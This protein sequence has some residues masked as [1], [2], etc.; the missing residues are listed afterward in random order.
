ML[1]PQASRFWHSAIQSGLMDVQGLTACW[2]AIPPEKRDAPEHLDRRLA[3]QAVQRGH[4]TLWQAQQLLAGR[5]NG[6]R[7]DRYLLVD[8]IGHGGMGRVYLARDTR[9][10]RQ[11]ALKILAPERMNN[12]RAIARFQREARVGAQ[13]Q[14]ENLVRIYDFGESNGRHFLVMEY[15]EGKTIG[16]L[17]TQQGP[18]PAATAAR[19]ARQIALGLEHAHRK[20]LIHRDVN[21][22]NILVSHEGIAK[23]ADLG[24]AID[25]AEEERVT[26]EG[27]TVGTFDYVAPEQARHSHAADIRSDIYSLGC[28]LYHM[29]AGHVPF[30]SPSLPEK[31]FAHQAL[32]PRP[33]DQ[34]AD[35]P[36][37]LVDVVQRMMRKLP[38]GRYATPLQVAQA[39]EPFVEDYARIREGE[40]E[41]EPQAADEMGQ[42]PRLPLPQPGGGDGEIPGRTGVGFGSPANPTVPPTG[43]A[44]RPLAATGFRGGRQGEGPPGAGLETNRPA[45]A[46]SVLTPVNG[47]ELADA[48]DIPLILDLGPEPA[49]TD[50][51]PRARSW[52]G[53]DKPGKLSGTADFP[54]GEVEPSYVLSRGRSLLLEHPWAWGFALL[55]AALM[56]LLV[57]FLAAQWLFAQPPPRTPTA[58]RPR[59]AT[60]KKEES[61]PA[62]IVV[63]TSDGAEKPV[64]DLFEALNEAVGSRGSIVLRDDAPFQLSSATRPLALSAARAGWVTIKAADGTQPVLIADLKGASPLLAVGGRMNLTL[65]GL[66]IVAR[67]ADTPPG[68]ALVPLIRST[69]KIQLRHCTFR[70]E[71]GPAPTCA[72]AIYSDGGDLT[73]E[74]C[75]FEGFPTALEIHALGGL[76]TSLKQTMIVPA[77]PRSVSPS[78]RPAWGLRVEFMSG[79]RGSSQRKLSLDQCTFVGSG[80]V[81]L[82]GFSPQYPFHVEPRHCAVQAEALVAWEPTSREVPL[83]RQSVQWT[84]R[85]NHL[86]ITSPS[87]VVMSSAMTPAL[88]KGITDLESWSRIADEAAPIRGSIRFATSPASRPAVPRPADFAIEATGPDRAGADPEQVGPKPRARPSRP[89]V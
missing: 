60:P 28:T 29:I 26:R 39:L 4:L 33:L 13:L 12:P 81:Q 77:G 37:G 78:D 9:L 53:G 74:N 36:P 55:M 69:Y 42:P 70:V 87:W 71:N 23:L 40:P 45:A 68:K 20:G 54:P 6:F 22:Y 63:L 18:M 17:L 44:S 31:L 2:D 5:T 56:L 34:L 47:D 82:A 67:Y 89:S 64:S 72:R 43:P 14:H 32:E 65:D 75:F 35:V 49:L 7:V 24:L 30:P 57:A 8:L 83:D 10:N 84:G 46:P 11:V 27:A 88:T 48:E 59:A 3:R 21:P 61:K 62:P 16:T 50:T 76:T 52:F 85:G 51:P 79:N 1:E 73:V 66:T 25:L 41:P 58:G 80:L 19:L 86:N 15:I 38:D